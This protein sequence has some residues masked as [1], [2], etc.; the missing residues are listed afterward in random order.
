[1]NGKGMTGTQSGAVQESDSAYYERL[2][3]DLFG[4]GV[5]VGGVGLGAIG[6]GT[7]GGGP[8]AVAGGTLGAIPGTHVMG[9]AN[10]P[11]IQDVWL[12]Q[13]MQRIR[14]DLR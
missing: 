8:G 4:G 13:M 6:G 1:M 14:K 2:L 7:I 10:E 11:N 9:N 3:Q 5:T 12:H